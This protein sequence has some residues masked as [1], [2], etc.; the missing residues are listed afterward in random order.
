[1]NRPD[2]PLADAQA[3]TSARATIL[4][5]ALRDAH[6]V[7]AE[8]IRIDRILRAAH[9]SSSSLYHHFASRA[10][11]IQA[12]RTEQLRKGFLAEDASILDLVER[13]DSPEEFSA[14]MAGQ[15]RRL[16]ED[17]D[18]VA[19]RR[20]RLASAAAGLLSPGASQHWNDQIGDL[21]D[22]TAH[23]MRRAVERGLC[24][25]GLDPMAYAAFFT[26]LSLGQLTAGSRT[27]LESWLAVATTAALAPLR[28]PS[29]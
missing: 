14:F 27:D 24:N 20:A 2:E 10:G 19:R 9:A 17:A 1:V 15:L 6:E 28:F 25:P 21:H 13:M 8:N 5:E 18:T 16:V 4:A 12:V 29:P 7:G 26:S 23:F 11:L 22:A 3:D